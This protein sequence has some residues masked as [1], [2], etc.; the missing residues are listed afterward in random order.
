MAVINMSDFL[1]FIGE[2]L[3]EEDVEGLRFILEGFTGKFAPVKFRPLVTLQLTE[4]LKMVHH[5]W[6]KRFFGL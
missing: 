5:S 1:R 4:Y 3:K 2:Q 6:L